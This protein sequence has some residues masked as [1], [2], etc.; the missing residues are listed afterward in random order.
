M[1][2]SDVSDLQLP[3]AV[4]FVPHSL[5]DLLFELYALLA[6][7][8]IRYSLPILVYL[9]GCSIE[10]GPLFVRLKCGLIGVGR[11]VYRPAELAKA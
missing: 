8:F 9:W 11:D 4:F 2:T 6:A 10:S 3:F 5:H 7:I 1:V